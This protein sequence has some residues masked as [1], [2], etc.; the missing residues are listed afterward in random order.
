MILPDRRLAL[1]ADDR[2]RYPD[3]WR[4]GGDVHVAATDGEDLTDPSGCA[5]HHLDDHSE[6]TIWPRAGR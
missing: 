3:C 4:R 1:A 5:E 6:V 2:S